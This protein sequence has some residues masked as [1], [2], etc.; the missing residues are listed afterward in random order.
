MFENSKTEHEF[1]VIPEVQNYVELM[2]FWR[3][4]DITYHSNAEPN[5]V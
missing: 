4:N 1:Y 5:V 2:E 3:R